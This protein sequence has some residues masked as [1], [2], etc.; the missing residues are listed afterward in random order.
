MLAISYACFIKKVSRTATKRL[1]PLLSIYWDALSIDQPFVYIADE[2]TVEE[3]K[4]HLD[5][6][7][8]KDEPWKTCTL[9]SPGIA[10]AA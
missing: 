1:F 2:Q 6:I 7:N 10:L 4:A 8:T 5:G 9:D 3:L